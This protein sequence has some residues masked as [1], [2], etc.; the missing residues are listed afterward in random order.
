MGDL[1]FRKRLGHPSYINK[2]RS[3]KNMVW[4]GKR[5][6]KDRKKGY[7]GGSIMARCL[8][9]AMLQLWA[10]SCIFEI[11]SMTD[12]T[13]LLFRNGV[14]IVSMARDHVPFAWLLLGLCVSCKYQSSKSKEE[15]EFQL[16]GKNRSWPIQYSFGY[17]ALWEKMWIH[18]QV[19]FTECRNNCWANHG[20]RACWQSRCGSWVIFE[21]L[22]Y[23]Y[24]CWVSWIASIRILKLPTEANKRMRAGA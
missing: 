14:H 2:D 15:M 8:A 10:S 20:F 11:I 6:Q 13:G 19:P 5:P 18:P 7:G 21:L 24:L 4:K 1:C 22:F 12:H 16:A 23:H 17:Q 9:L 3:S